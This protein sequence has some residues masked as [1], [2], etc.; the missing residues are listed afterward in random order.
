MAV[1]FHFEDITLPLRNRNKL[2]EYILQRV[3][4]EGLKVD[5][6]SYIFCTDDYL[7][8]LNKNYLQHD[9]YTDILTF[10]LSEASQKIAAE[11]YISG[12]RVRENAATFETSFA[13]ELHRVI[14]HGA[15][16][17]CGYN[18][19]SEKEKKVMRKKENDWLKDYFTGGK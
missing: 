11:I 17:L 19:H 3:D 10:D 18:D 16:H 5:R 6:L 12:E 4:N 13:E 1:H 8:A 15:L 7:L 9:T 14:F 2:K